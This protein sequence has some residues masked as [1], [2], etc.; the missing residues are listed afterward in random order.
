MNSAE[1]VAELRRRVAERRAEGKYP[2]GLEQQLSAEFDAIMQVVHRGGDSIVE[3][4][5]AIDTLSEQIEKVNGLIAPDSRFPGGRLYHRLT[6]RLVGR[7]TR[8]VAEQVREVLRGNLEV[9]RI[10][11][12]QLQQQRDTDGRVLNQVTHLMLDRLLMI[13]VLAQAVMEM[14]RKAGQGGH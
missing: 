12:R 2:L 5:L 9:L 1:T 3:L 13:D 10:V 8:G 11:R 6:G 7:H 4:N 14:E